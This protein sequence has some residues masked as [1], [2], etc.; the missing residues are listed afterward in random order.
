LCLIYKLKIET[1]KNHNKIFEKQY[2]ETS[3]NLYINSI[4]KNGKEE[5]NITKNNIISFENIIDKILD[6]Y[7]GKKQN[8]NNNNIISYF[9]SHYFLIIK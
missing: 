2:N 3:Y 5:K 9:F 4:N 6:Y 8:D 7:K 1:I